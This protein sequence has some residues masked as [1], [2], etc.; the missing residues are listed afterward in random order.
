MFPCYLKIRNFAAQM[1]TLGIYRIDLKGMR[2]EVET[3]HYA[4]DDDFFAVVGSTEIHA[5]NVAVE[6][7]VAKAAGDT[8]LLTFALQ[9]TVTVTCDRCL[10]DMVCDIDTVRELKVAFA[11]AYAD[12]GDWVKVPADDGGLNVAWHIYEFIT[13]ELP[14]QRVHADGDCNPAMMEILEHHT[15]GSAEGN[16]NSDGA[17]DSRWDELKKI[18]DNN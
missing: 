6:L 2:S 12:E 9:G 17:T 1:D 4:V 3:H 10:D 11:E 15:A 18:I 5:G 8:F 7:T 14:L 16:G 13:L